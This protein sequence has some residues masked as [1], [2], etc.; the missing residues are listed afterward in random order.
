[1]LEAQ[2]TERRIAPR[3]RLLKGGY[4][5]FNDGHS[6]IDCRV[7]N[8]SETGARLEVASVIGVPDRFDLVLADKSAR[9]PCRLVWR[10]PGA[11]G[12]AFEQG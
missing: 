2:D 11:V 7:R 5:V 3:R 9:R 6:T 10:S 1:M 4:I 12:V 8:L